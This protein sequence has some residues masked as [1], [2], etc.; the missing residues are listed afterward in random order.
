MGLRVCGEPNFV[1]ESIDANGDAARQ[2]GARIVHCC[3]FDSIPS[4]LG[5]HRLQALATATLGGP[6]PR[7]KGRVEAFVGAVSGG[8]VASTR[9][10]LGKAEEDPAIG[11]LL[12]NPFA[13]APGFAGPEQPK[14]NV[15]VYDE[16]L[17]SWSAPFLM[18]DINTKIV[19]C[20]NHRLGHP[21]G[22]DFVYDETTATG[23]GEE[24]RRRA[25]SLADPFAAI[26]G[27]GPPPEPGEGPSKEQR[28][29]G[30]FTLAFHGRH[31]DG[32]VGVVRVRGFQDPGYGS[33]SKRI[34]ESA[35]CLLFDAVAVP[36]G[37]WSP[38][39]ATGE[40]L[41]A[42][43]TSRGVLEVTEHVP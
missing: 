12:H 43:L 36:G 25:E 33:T 14:G 24:G 34:V 27:E 21:Y 30:H 18:A 32:R 29:A 37:V 26:V 41:L 39:A 7:V 17:D 42:R 11:A 28:E 6:F 3:G 16:D 4:D 13:L 2:S 22:T 8:T 35:L 31:P 15:P 38:A 5:V 9:V 19:R 40:A 10:V 20:S 23:P 1:R